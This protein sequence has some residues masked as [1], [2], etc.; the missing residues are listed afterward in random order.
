MNYRCIL[1]VAGKQGRKNQEKKKKQRRRNKTSLGGLALERTNSSAAGKLCVAT[2]G[3]YS[4]RYGLRAAASVAILS[5]MEPHRFPGKPCLRFCQILQ[6]SFLSAE[7]S[8]Q[9]V[10]RHRMEVQS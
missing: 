2:P 3:R 5:L 10:Q 8:W 1:P 9:H 7:C 6:H 4:C